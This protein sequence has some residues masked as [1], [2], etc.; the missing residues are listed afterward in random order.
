MQKAKGGA[1]EELCTAETTVHTKEGDTQEMGG[2]GDEGEVFCLS[3][4]GD[5]SKTGKWEVPYFFVWMLQPSHKTH[6]L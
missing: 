4:G 6:G 5:G 3:P 1:G 2:G